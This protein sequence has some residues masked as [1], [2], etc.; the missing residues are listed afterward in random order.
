VATL[1]LRRCCTLAE[2]GNTPLL[3]KVESR[4]EG[5]GGGGAVFAVFSCGGFVYAEVSLFL[6]IFPGGVSSIADMFLVSQIK[7]Q[8]LAV[9]VRLHI[10]L[11]VI[12]FLQ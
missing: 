3:E 10:V 2:L 6:V 12:H 8:F 7:Q 5:G 11:L 9:S 4:P 1:R